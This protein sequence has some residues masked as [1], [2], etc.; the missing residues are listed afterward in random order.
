MAFFEAVFSEYY[1]LLKELFAFVK[2]R[3]GEFNFKSLRKISSAFIRCES[4]VEWLIDLDLVMPYKKK[5]GT[6]RI[7]IEDLELLLLNLNDKGGFEEQLLK[8]YSSYLLKKKLT[9][10]IEDRE[11]LKEAFKISLEKAGFFAQNPINKAVFDAYP[12]IQ[13]LKYLL[14]E[15]YGVFEST[16]K[17][18]EKLRSPIFDESTKLVWNEKKN[19]GYFVVKNFLNFKGEL[20]E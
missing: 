10:E 1:N 17:L 13:Y 3:R 2:L 20:Y 15:K 5:K 18:I 4:L 6:F 16:E 11:V 8:D 12:I 14:I 7:P 9:D 19:S